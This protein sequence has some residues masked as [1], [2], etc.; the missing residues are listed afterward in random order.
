MGPPRRSIVPP[1]TLWRPSAAAALGGCCV[2]QAGASP[3]AV[4]TILGHAS[5][6]FTLSVY[7]HVF[8]CDLDAIGDVLGATWAQ[9]SRDESVTWLDDRAE[10]GDETPSYLRFRGGAGRARTCD[11]R[12][13]SPLRAYPLTCRVAYKPTL[14]CGF[15]S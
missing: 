15:E 12:I 11:R 8:P 2:D 4:Q 3:K 9:A 10:R 6:G 14:T 5:A 13:M 1:T 7:R